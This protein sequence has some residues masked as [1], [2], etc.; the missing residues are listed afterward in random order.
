MSRFFSCPITFLA[1]ALFACR[2]QAEPTEVDRATAR[3][4]ASAGYH[5]L[6]QGDYATAADHFRRADALVHAPTLVVDWGRALAGLGFLVE[7]RERFALVLREGVEPEAPPSWHRA[8]ADARSEFEALEP[9]LAWLTLVV[10]GPNE[11]AITIDRARVPD[12]ALGVP[13][14]T[15]PGTHEIRVRAPGYVSEARTVALVEGE[16]KRLEIALAAKPSEDDG[17]ERATTPP[18]LAKPPR[19]APAPAAIPKEP[20]DAGPTRG[21]AYAAF[22]AGGA[23]LVVSAVT[24]ALALSQRSEL[25]SVCSGG[26]CPASERGAIED[27]HRLGTASGI[28]LGIGVLGIGT[29]TALLLTERSSSG[30]DRGPQRGARIWPYV[31]AGTIGAIGRY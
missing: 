18:R 12:A 16:R 15:N 29:G 21:L 23:G 4:L 9:R 24:G 1:V 22:A 13:R 7:A 8:H 19:S 5:A 3:E 6:K 25:Q 10:R 28:S 11:P 31:G 27:Y 30:S 17:A 14:A 2:V 20:D 26:V